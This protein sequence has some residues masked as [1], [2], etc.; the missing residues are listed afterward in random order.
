M[1][2]SK[3]F[4]KD[5]KKYTVSRLDSL[6]SSADGLQIQNRTNIE[7]DIAIYNTGTKLVNKQNE[8][9]YTISMIT[10]YSENNIL[11]ILD[12]IPFNNKTYTV[13]DTINY[14]DYSIYKATSN[15]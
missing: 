5:I 9:S 11:K 7:V 10:I 8:D 14:L 6:S 2:S 1:K 15:V 12:N 13:L 3:I 4:K